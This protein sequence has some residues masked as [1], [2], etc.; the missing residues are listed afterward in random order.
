MVL[1]LI[2]ILERFLDFWMRLTLLWKDFK[3]TKIF[4]RYFTQS[5]RIHENWVFKENV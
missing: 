2:K 1:T 5:F 3:I 4:V